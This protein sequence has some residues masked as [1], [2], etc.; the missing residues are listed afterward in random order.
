MRHWER[1][2]LTNEGLVTSYLIAGDAR[3]APLVLLHDGAWGGS[4]EASWGSSIARLAEEY[5]VLAPDLYG[6]GASSKMV[7]LDVAPYHFRL[8]QVARLLDSLGLEHRP[9]HLVGNSFGGAMALRAVVESWFSHRVRSSVSISGT[10][11]PYRTKESLESLAH[12]D[13]TREDMHRIVRL[14]AGDFPN[15]DSYVDL[16]LTDACNSGHFRAVSSAGL[17]TPFRSEPRPADDYPASLKRSRVPVTLVTDPA[18]TL[19]EPGWA[20]RIAAHSSRCAVRLTAGLHSP[21][22]SDP[23]GTAELILDILR[24]HESDSC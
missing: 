13:G 20:E 17:A 14:L 6:F 16:R 8:R 23:V 19:V 12:F 24:T 1:R 3:S 11:G 15:I 9:A 4:A 2:S 5:L 18:D 10:G 7:Q 21:N 22:I